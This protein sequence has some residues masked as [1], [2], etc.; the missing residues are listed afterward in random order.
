VRPLCTD[1]SDFTAH[2]LGPSSPQPRRIDD[3]PVSEL[4]AHPD[5][6]KHASGYCNKEI[7]ALS[8]RGESVYEDPITVTQDGLV[9]EGYA[10]WQLAK[11]QK[12]KTIRCIVRE[13][14]KEQALIHI[15]GR[16]LGSKGINDFVRILLALELEAWFK[17]QAKGNQR[18]GGRNKGSSQLTEADRLDVRLEIARAAGVS[19]GN[20][21]KVKHIL[22]SAEPEL[23]E[24]LRQGEISISRGATWAKIPP[25]GQRQRLAHGRQRR[26]IHKTISI[27]LKKHHSTHPRICDGLRDIQRGFRRLQ[28]EECLLQ[29]SD[30]IEGV[31]RGVDLLLTPTEEAYRAS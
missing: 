25:A 31:I 23:R 30:P 10:L 18:M 3:R 15:I 20:V 5:L 1:T 14:G 4:K 13:M 12:R 6:I 21:S 9:I 26:G 17:E 2:Q 11:L 22:R 27:L 28:Q 16:N 8:E 19:V 7:S 24:A 29:L